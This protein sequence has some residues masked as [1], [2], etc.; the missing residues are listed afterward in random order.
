MIRFLGGDQRAIML[1]DKHLKTDLGW[2]V[3]RLETIS[4]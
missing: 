2:S 3:K 1:D 4:I